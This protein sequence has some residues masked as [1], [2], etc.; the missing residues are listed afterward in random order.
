MN[1]DERLAAVVTAL[2]AVGLSC[3]VMGGHAV[4]FYGFHRYTSDFDLHLS[5]DGWADLSD[6]L[7]G[8]P[9]AAAGPLHLSFVEIARRRY[10]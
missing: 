5:A 3:L 1:P 2:E 7:N 4:R 6:R 9:L 10:Y 8:S